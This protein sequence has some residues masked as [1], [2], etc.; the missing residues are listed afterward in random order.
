MGT[1]IKCSSCCSQEENKNEVKYGSREY[2]FK[3]RAS[4]NINNLID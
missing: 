2:R 1:T 4:I 3:M